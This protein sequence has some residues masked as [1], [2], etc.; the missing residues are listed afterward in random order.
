MFNPVR[1]WL[2]RCAVRKARRLECARWVLCRAMG[3]KRWD[4]LTEK[5]RG[6]MVRAVLCHFGK[7]I[8]K[9]TGYNENN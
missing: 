5:E 9:R 1:L 6:P 4:E 7:N 3:N 8:I 2:E